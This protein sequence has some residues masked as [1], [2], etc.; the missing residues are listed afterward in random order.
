MHFLIAGGSGFIGQHLK[1]HLIRQGHRVSILSRDQEKGDE[2]W[3][4]FLSNWDDFDVIVNLCGLGIADRRW[5]GKRKQDLTDSRLVPTQQLIHAYKTQSHQPRLLQ[6]S[7]FV[8]Y[9]PKATLQTEAD[10]TAQKRPKAFAQ[11]LVGNWERLARQAQDDGATVVTARFGLVMGQGGLLKKLKPAFQYG[12]GHVIGDGSQGFSWVHIDD[13]TASLLWLAQH[14]AP[15]TIYNITAPN[16]VSQ[17]TFAN[18]LG[19]VLGRRVRLR[20]PGWMIRLMFGQMGQELLIQGHW[21]QPARLQAQGFTFQY[22]TLSDALT[23]LV[24]QPELRSKNDDEKNN[25]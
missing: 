17:K 12:F 19:Q 2:T 22:P 23:S 6:A 4:T 14:D 5:S 13:L 20:L 9:D 24:K 11:W 10:Q 25:Y 1:Q 21:I 15:D 16:P 8:Y 3:Q 18:T 7:A